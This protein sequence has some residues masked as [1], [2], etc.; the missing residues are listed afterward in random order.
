LGEGETNRQDQKPVRTIQFGISQRERGKLEAADEIIKSLRASRTGIVQE[1]R[2]KQRTGIVQRPIQA[3]LPVRRPNICN[4][5]ELTIH[6][7]SLAWR[8]GTGHLFDTER[9]QELI[10]IQLFCICKIL[11]CRGVFVFQMSPLT[12]SICRK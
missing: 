7:Q 1:L 6:P 5:L 2:N 12:V 10:I 3:K 11:W 4:L 9:A 8:L